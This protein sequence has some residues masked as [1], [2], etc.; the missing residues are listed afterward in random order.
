VWIDAQGALMH[1]RRRLAISPAKDTVELR[2][3]AETDRTA[4][5]VVQSSRN[6]APGWFNNTHRKTMK[7]P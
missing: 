6:N 5:P 3:V 1:I 2:Q 4:R 7:M